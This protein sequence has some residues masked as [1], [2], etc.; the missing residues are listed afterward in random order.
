[1]KPRYVAAIKRQGDYDAIAVVQ[2]VPCIWCGQQRGQPCVPKTGWR[3]SRGWPVPPHGVR[4]M[5]WRK[6]GSPP[7][8]KR[9]V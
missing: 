6:A 5:A 3:S 9:D 4:L 1:M 7:R 2:A 8:R